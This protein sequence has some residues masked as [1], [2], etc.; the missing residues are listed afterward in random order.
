MRAVLVETLQ[1]E[2]NVDVVEED[3]E[4]E[5]SLGVL[6]LDDV[7]HL[8]ADGHVGIELAECGAHGVDHHVGVEDDVVGEDDG[9]VLLS[10]QGFSRVLWYVPT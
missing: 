6:H 9:E 3:I 7:S 10:H 1:H 5:G 4:V 2:V 8:L